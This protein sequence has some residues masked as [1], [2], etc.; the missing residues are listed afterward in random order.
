MKT[1]YI[2][3][4]AKILILINNIINISK[5]YLF[6]KHDFM[7]LCKT[8]NTMHAHTQYQNSAA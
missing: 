4:N 3:I 6:L 7:P 2:K 8:N 1:E 5:Y